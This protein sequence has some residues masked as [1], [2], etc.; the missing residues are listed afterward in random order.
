L[1]EGIT[2]GI[3]RIGVRK[4]RYAFASRNGG[5]AEGEK[6]KGD[7][8]GDEVEEMHVDRSALG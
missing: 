1:P 4:E 2:W 8:K 5:G 3:V 7:E 6:E